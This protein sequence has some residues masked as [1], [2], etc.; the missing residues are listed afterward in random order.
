MANSGLPFPLLRVPLPDASEPWSV[1]VVLTSLTLD[2][3]DAL[4]HRVVSEGDWLSAF[5]A[6]LVTS[7]MATE[8]LNNATMA[9]ACPSFSAQMLG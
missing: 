9:A 6:D 2:V 1:R 4:R 3:Y 5:V 7:V 8:S